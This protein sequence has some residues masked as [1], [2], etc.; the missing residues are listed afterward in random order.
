MAAVS[1]WNDPKIWL[2]A[3]NNIAFGMASAYLNGYINGTW[4]KEALGSGALIGFLGAIICAIATVSSKIYGVVSDRLGS[5]VY[6]LVFGS[7]CFALMAVLSFITAPNGKGPGGW[8][9]G[10]MVF[11]VL[12]GLGRG[13]Y[14]STNKGIFGD[15]FP[16]SKGT[17]AFANCMMQNT[18]ASTIGFVLG[19]LKVDSSEVWILLV[20]SALSVPGLLFAQFLLRNEREQESHVKETPSGSNISVGGA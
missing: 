18:L 3:G 8:G 1:L 4:Q 6:V 19:A 16:G 17:G 10:I 5:K 14:E 2:I 20:F 9:W 12:Q 15:I 11:Y 13:V 7:L